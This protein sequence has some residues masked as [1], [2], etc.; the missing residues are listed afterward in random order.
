MYHEGLRTFPIR[1]LHVWDFAGFVHLRIQNLETGK[2]YEISRLLQ[3]DI[4]YCLWEIASL[5]F[6]MNLATK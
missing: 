3:A 2:V 4:E 5:D 1:Q 6:I